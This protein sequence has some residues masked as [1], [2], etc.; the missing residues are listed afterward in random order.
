ML[1]FLNCL[2]FV[3][4]NKVF[5]NFVSEGRKQVCVCFVRA[6]KRMR[7]F[8]KE[9]SEAREGTW[10]SIIAVIGDGAK[11]ELAGVRRFPYSRFEF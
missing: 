1:N 10:D 4:L 7:C 6:K 8:L 3:S 2:F 9:C 11:S 5:R